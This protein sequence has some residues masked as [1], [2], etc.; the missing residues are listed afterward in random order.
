MPARPQPV[1]LSLLNP[2]N[3]PSGFTLAVPDALRVLSSRQFDAEQWTRFVRELNAVLSKAPGT[4]AKEVTDFWLVSLITLGAASTS[5][6]IYAKRI[7]QK[8]LETVERWNRV[9]LAQMGL[10][11]RLNETTVATHEENV[12]DSH[13]R[14]HGKRFN[15]PDSTSASV[16]LEL[17]VDR[18]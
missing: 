4:I 1:R 10:H 12:G 18:L 14:R 15:E 8:A 5:T 7:R 6:K 9:D 17:V 2:R 11:V 13:Y 3:I 16:S